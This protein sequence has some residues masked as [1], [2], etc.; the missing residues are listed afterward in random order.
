MKVKDLLSKYDGKFYIYRNV[1][2]EYGN[3][4]DNECIA[5]NTIYEDESKRKDMI[6]S[7]EVHDF[8]AGHFFLNIYLKDAE[9]KQSDD[10]MNEHIEFLGFPTR[11]KNI[12]LR[13]KIDTVGKLCSKTYFDIYKLRT[14][15]RG[16]MNEI[17]EVMEIYNLHLKEDR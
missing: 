3:I 15:G 6:M 8:Q 9:L 2:N 5:T 12:L 1:Y 13:G 17:I 4:I 16:S 14:M 7:R 10:I 11:I